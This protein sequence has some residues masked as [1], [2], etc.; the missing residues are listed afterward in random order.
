MA[1][2]PWWQRLKRD[3][4]A[5][6]LSQVEAVRQLI[7]YADHYVPSD[8]ESVLKAWKRWESGS[9]KGLPT[10]ENQRAIAKL[11]GTVRDAYFGPPAPV[12]PPLPL[13]DGS[14]LELVQRLRASNVDNA[15]L[16][17]AR[18]LTDR[19]CTDYAAHPGAAVLEEAQGLLAEIAALKERNLA[20]KQLRE[21]YEIAGWLSLLV[22]CLHYDQGN[23]RAA[24]SARA[25]AIMLAEEIGHGEILGWA[26]EIRAWIA[27]TRGDYYAVLAAAKEGLKASPHHSVAVQLQG[28]SAKAWARLGDRR[29]V[30]LA[31]ER[32]RELLDA[33]PY[34]DNPRNHFQVD[35]S[36][37]DFYAMD[38]YRAVGEDAMA[39]ALADAVRATSITPGGEVIAP[40]RLAEA[41]LTKATVFARA[42]EVDLAAETAEAGLG[43]DRRSLPSLLMVGN[44]V[45]AVM[46]RLHPRND[47][48]IEFDHHLH[49]LGHPEPTPDEQ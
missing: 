43:R 2:E 28:Q 45:S 30:E 21:V 26:A 41:E 48:A 19:L 17:M 10:A 13:A 18:L 36:K 40:M 33:L 31:L 12:A 35:P 39:M 47:T 27:L 3:R 8:E 29:Q 23:E 22:A 32:G 49:L 9:L 42:G 24:E 16:D 14:T 37:F 15:D 6:G 7:A 20:F 5:R 46:R 38:C 34:P 44:E 11:F 4:E 25:G 1:T